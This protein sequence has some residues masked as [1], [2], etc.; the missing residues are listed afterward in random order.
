[1]QR[2]LAVLALWTLAGCPP[3]APSV[4]APSLPVGHP[5][6]KCPPGTRPAGHAPPHG[7]EVWCEQPLPDGSAQREGPSIA[8]HGNEQR[9]AEGSYVAGKQN[10]PWLYWF[11]T[12]T[13]ETQGSFAMGVK[14]GV[15][16][17][18]QPNGERAAEGQFVDGK[19]HGPWTYWNPDALT[20]T[21]GSF[22]L[23]LREGVW[24]D[25]GPDGKAVRERVYRAGRM[26]T[27]RE[28]TS[29]R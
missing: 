2:V 22:V 11:P 4:T 12:G 24:I 9:K 6:L 1:M 27:V 10:G 25:Y 13:P 15:W 3:K 28:L 26:I 19:E 5:D 23:G 14:E 29:P 21:E 7:Y 8:W 16:T 17:T 20:R 18:F